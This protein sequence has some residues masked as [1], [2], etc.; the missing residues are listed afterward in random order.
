MYKR[1][2]KAKDPRRPAGIIDLVKPIP[3]GRIAL[4]CPKCRQVTRI[5]FS[6]KEDKKVRICR[7][8]DQEV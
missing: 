4:L 6:L 1:H 2:T 5:G 3:V 7:K 8:C